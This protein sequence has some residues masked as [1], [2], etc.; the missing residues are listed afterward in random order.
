MLIFPSSLHL[1]FFHLGMYLC[2]LSFPLPLPLPL[3][4]HLHLH[5]HLDHDLDRDPGCNLGR[6]PDLDP[7]RE[8]KRCR[9]GCGDLA[10]DVD[11]DLDL[12]TDRAS[13]RLH[14]NPMTP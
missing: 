13:D 10:C 5:I 12:D 9:G 6:H 3:H 2:H 14:L 1:S 8:R 7:G 11:G 4:Q